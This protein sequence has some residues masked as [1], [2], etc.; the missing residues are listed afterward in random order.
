MTSYTDDEFEVNTDDEYEINQELNTD[1][2]LDSGNESTLINIDES[3]DNGEQSQEQE[4]TENSTNNDNSSIFNLG[5]EKFQHNIYNNPKNTETDLE[6]YFKALPFTFFSQY[7]EYQIYENSKKIVVPKELLFKISQFDNITLPI[8]VKINDLDIIFGI[9]DYFEYIDHI[10]LP[11]ETF[12]NFNFIENEE[13][14]LS[15]IK[16][17]PP[18]ATLLGIKPLSEE[19]YRIQDIK[20]YLETTLKKMV[21]SL[22]LD[23]VIRLPYLETCINIQ[24]KEIEPA[25]IV[26]I[27][28]LESVEINILPMIEP[29][30]IVDDSTNKVDDVI[31]DNNISNSSDNRFT[32][33]PIMKT[34]FKLNNKPN[35]NNKTKKEN[36]EDNEEKKFV[37]FSGKGNTLG[38]K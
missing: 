35:F 30:C 7:D 3:L 36:E 20:H 28:D 23:E 9:I 1:V 11:T 5:L 27:F 16:N 34:N 26:S 13:L 38:S 6:Y 19:F 32:T 22:T 10:Y 14:K 29:S 17:K 24:I 8:Y 15:V 18:N 4:S 33:K 12:Y 21:I 2:M 31:S 37:S 25:P